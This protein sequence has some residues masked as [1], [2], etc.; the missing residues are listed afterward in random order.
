MDD[1]DIKPQVASREEARLFT[2]ADYGLL[3]ASPDATLDRLIGL[4]R[5]L[6][7]TPIAAFSVLDGNNQYFRSSAGLGIRQT[8]RE[9][10]FC[11][12]AVDQQSPLVVSDTHL[13]S[14][15]RQNPLVT[16]EPC[17]RSYAGIPVKAPNGVVVG[18]MCVIDQRP[19][20]FSELQLAALDDIRLL[21]E[22]TLLLRS[23][24]LTDPLTGLYN[25]RH[26]EHVM[27]REWRRAYRHLLPLSVLL[28]DIDHFKRYNDAYGH[29]AG[30]DCLKQVARL[31][32]A[33]AKRAADLAARFGG[34]EFLLLLPETPPEGAR[35]IADHLLE[36]VRADAIPHAGTPTGALTLSIGGAVAESFDDLNRGERHLLGAADRALYATKR[37]NRDGACVVR[38]SESPEIVEGTT[39]VPTVS[40][41]R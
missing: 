12:H 1:C 15:F 24:S 21:I 35:E 40:R 29:L 13:D 11:A 18:A 5:Q 22:E 37:G 41:R 7:D 28:I 4:A 27:S 32:S 26:L 39:A 31:V 17:I 25:R 34:E 3:E 38:M 8:P 6:L 10:S 9:H 33:Q 23:T 2:L 20:Q 14:R 36:R 30:D 19:R 16:G